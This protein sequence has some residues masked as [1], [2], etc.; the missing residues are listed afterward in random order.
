MAR[1]D[2]TTI[3]IRTSTRDLLVRICRLNGRTPPQQL[4]RLVVAEARRLR[5]DAES[6]EPRSEYMK[7]PEQ[8]E[9]TKKEAANIIAPM[10]SEPP[11]ECPECGSGLLL[12][13]NGVVRKCARQDCDFIYLPA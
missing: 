11:S 1:R 8:P 7:I 13:A 12:Q 2:H 6:S 3:S 9:M 10:A 4:E 5:L